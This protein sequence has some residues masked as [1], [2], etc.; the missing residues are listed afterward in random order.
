MNLKSAIEKIETIKSEIDLAFEKGS[1]D[2]D[3]IDSRL[4]ALKI[5][6]CSMID[7]NSV[8][9]GDYSKQPSEFV[10]RQSVRIEDFR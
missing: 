10:S 5:D 8:E 4:D 6:L 7:T 3:L 1:I 9:T 2:F